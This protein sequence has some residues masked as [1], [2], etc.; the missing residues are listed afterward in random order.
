MRR[1]V[2]KLRYCPDCGALVEIALALGTTIGPPTLVCPRCRV[3]LDSGRREWEAH[4][5][6]WRLG[7]AAR[8]LAWWGAWLILLIPASAGAGL[9]AMAA[10]GRS[11]VAAIVFLAGYPALAGAAAGATLWWRLRQVRRS[12]ERASPAPSQ[13]RRAA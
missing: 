5:R 10:T 6:A 2:L 1:G 9:V 8:S 12:R 11:D 7:F 13:L 4:D 3:V